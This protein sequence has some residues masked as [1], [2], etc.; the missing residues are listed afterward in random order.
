MFVNNRV[1]TEIKYFKDHNCRTAPF[2]GNDSLLTVNIVELE[3]GFEP[4]ELSG[5]PDVAALNPR[6]LGH[7]LGEGGRVP[8]P[9]TVSGSLD[10]VHSY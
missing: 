1:K 8:G 2:P 9:E 6:G 7:G 10:K 3:K 4:G 5:R